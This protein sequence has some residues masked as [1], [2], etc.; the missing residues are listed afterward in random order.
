MCVRACW[1]CDGKW[2]YAARREFFWDLQWVWDG[3]GLGCGVWF[4]QVRRRDCLEAWRL[5]DQETVG[6][7]GGVDKL[8]AGLAET[9]SLDRER[10]RAIHSWLA[11]YAA[12]H[13]TLPHS[14]H[15][16]IGIYLL[17]I[18]RDSAWHAV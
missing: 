2:V 1:F 17:E 12:I 14:S 15:F 10:E 11:S 8:L 7:D 18:D 13:T 9:L 3:L 4:W 5:R 16:V 6:G